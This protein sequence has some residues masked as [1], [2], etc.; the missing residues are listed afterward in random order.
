MRLFAT[1][2]VFK[3]STN[4]NVAKFLESRG[5]LEDALEIATIQ[6]RILTLLYNL[7][8]LESQRFYSYFFPTLFYSNA[9]WSYNLKRNGVDAMINHY[10]Q[11]TRTYK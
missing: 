3:F 2:E 6:T 1:N 8:S 5:M 7:G 10:C 11:F 9:C 4:C